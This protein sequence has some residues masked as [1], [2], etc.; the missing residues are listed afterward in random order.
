MQ[1]PTA[2]QQKAQPAASGAYLE[3][4]VFVRDSL[5]VEADGCEYRTTTHCTSAVHC[6]R[7]KTKLQ[8][9][10]AAILGQ[11]R[12]WYGGNNLSNLQAICKQTVLS[13]SVLNNL[14]TSYCMYNKQC[15]RAAVYDDGSVQGPLTQDGGFASVV[16]A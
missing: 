7:V 3:L 14:A 16:Q 11:V 5:H 6:T 15:K 2:R 10:I 1:A 4:Y 12:T 8:R 9:M 13:A